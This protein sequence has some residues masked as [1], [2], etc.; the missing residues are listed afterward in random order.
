MVAVSFAA[1]RLRRSVGTAIADRSPIRATTK[2]VSS[3]V[4][5]SLEQNLCRPLR[6][7]ETRSICRGL[8][9][10]QR[11]HSKH[12]VRRPAQL[13][14]S[15][16]SVNDMQVTGLSRMPAVSPAALLLVDVN[17]QYSLKQNVSGG[18]AGAADARHRLP[19]SV[20]RRGVRCLQN[21]RWRTIPRRGVTPHHC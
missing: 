21:L 5:P 6:R 14:G 8:R 11:C 12:G 17:C 10:Q 19:A 7:R 13:Q 15:I 16:S 2:I 1:V 20:Y 18:S 9:G 4:K 3:R